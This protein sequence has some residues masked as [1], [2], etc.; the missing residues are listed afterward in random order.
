MGGGSEA[1]T[2]LCLRCFCVIRVHID[3]FFISLVSPLSTS[4]FSA[5]WI[6]NF[7]LCIIRLNPRRA[8]DIGIEYLIHNAAH[9][10]I[11]VAV[12]HEVLVVL[13]GVGY[14]KVIPLPAIPLREHAI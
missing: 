2:P 3:R 1:K 7:L 5:L 12:F 4:D 10:V 8:N 11:D 14:I 6:N 9:A 13:G